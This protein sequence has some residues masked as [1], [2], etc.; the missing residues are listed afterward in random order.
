MG[1]VVLM[2][3]LSC[4]HFGGGLKTKRIQLQVQPWNS[5]AASYVSETNGGGSGVTVVVFRVANRN[6]GVRLILDTVS[7]N[8]SKAKQKSPGRGRQ[9]PMMNLSD[10]FPC[11]LSYRTCGRQH[12]RYC[13]KDNFYG[14]GFVHAVNGTSSSDTKRSVVFVVDDIVVLL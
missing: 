13:S 7:I 1:V 11:H 2:V 4:C 12:P 5:T 6:C 9:V 8:G 3:L 10:R 14:G